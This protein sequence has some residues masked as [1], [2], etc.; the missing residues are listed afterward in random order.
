M[1]KK[2][3]STKVKTL[4]KFEDL[5]PLIQEMIILQCAE[6]KYGD[7]KPSLVSSKPWIYATNH[8]TKYPSAKNSGKWC[9]FVNKIEHDEWWVG[10]RECLFEGKLGEQIKTGTRVGDG[11]Y[12][13]KAV[14]IVYTYDYN[15]ESDVMRIRD[16]LRKIGIT[17][18]IPY[19]TDQATYEAK[20]AKTSREK[21]SL[22]FI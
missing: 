16:E 19:K 9:V 1:A 8:N 22:H 7:H 15:D 20:Y 13:N 4:L 17:W 3:K 11:I 5:D 21:V 18:K 2:I 10:I 14:I 6:A 12:K